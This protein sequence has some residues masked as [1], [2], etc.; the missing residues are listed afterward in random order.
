MKRM[1]PIGWFKR[2]FLT[3]HDRDQEVT[4][5]VLHSLSSLSG[6]PLLLVQAQDSGFEWC[7]AEFRAFLDGCSQTY[8]D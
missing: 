5:Q 4:L 3:P 2:T 6:A 7:E 1:S 8:Q